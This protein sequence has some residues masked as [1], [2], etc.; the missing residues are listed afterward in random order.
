[1]AK[2]GGGG[3]MFPQNPKRHTITGASK[4][5]GSFGEARRPACT[6]STL[7]KTFNTNENGIRFISL[8]RTEIRLKTFGENNWE[9][10][11]WRNQ[12]KKKKGL[13][14]IQSGFMINCSLQT[15]SE[16]NQSQSRN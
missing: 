14:N 6:L 1:M 10:C 11:V 13:T 3:R 8:H 12:M 16:F 15:S 7:M 2:H 5:L 9:F 4:R